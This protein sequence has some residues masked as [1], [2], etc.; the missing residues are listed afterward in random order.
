MADVRELRRELDRVV[1]DINELLQRR[2]G[3]RHAVE[4]IDLD[5]DNS[6]QEFVATT[7]RDPGDYYP[8]R[9]RAKKARRAKGHALKQTEQRL[10]QAKVEESRLQLLIYSYESNYRGSDPNELL[11]AA[12]HLLMHV[13]DQAEV[14]L[15]ESQMG[16][17][18]TLRLQA[19]YDAPK[20]EAS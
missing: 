2:E 7:G 12:Y 8:W 3:L 6:L 17:V 19:G 5:L 20:G 13:I 4:S 16:L 10:M 14:T 11:R 15:D 1:A 18:A 9:S